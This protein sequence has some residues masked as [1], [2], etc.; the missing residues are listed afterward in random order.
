MV[1]RDRGLAVVQQ[2]TVEGP[3]LSRVITRLFDVMTQPDW[4]AE[5]LRGVEIDE[6]LAWARDRKDVVVVNAYVDGALR[7]FAA[8]RQRP[9]G[10]E[11]LPDWYESGWAAPPVHHAADA[12]VRGGDPPYR[13]APAPERPIGPDDAVAIVQ[14]SSPNGTASTFTAELWAPDDRVELW[15]DGP[16]DA[17]LDTALTW[18]RR[19]AEVVVLLV[20]DAHGEHWFSAG[21]READDAR[22]AAALAQFDHLELP[23][24]SGPGGVG[25]R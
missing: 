24:W 25:T 17:P 23:P 11:V 4:P 15:A 3:D 14:P 21:T 2:Q 12:V 10:R 5:E 22:A 1:G 20:V 7:Q 6:A 9:R 16:V 13:V 8:S 18:A 19:A